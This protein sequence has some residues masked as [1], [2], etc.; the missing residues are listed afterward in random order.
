[1]TVTAAPTDVDTAAIPPLVPHV[2]VLFGATGDLARRKL[3]PGL[4]HLYQAGLLPD[5]RIVGV[6]LDQFDDE[7]F[8]EFALM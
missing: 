4:F 3:I 1:M 7:E 2:F 5:C 6:S 8:R